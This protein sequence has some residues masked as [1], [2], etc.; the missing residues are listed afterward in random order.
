MKRERVEKENQVKYPQNQSQSL[1]HA[2]VIQMKFERKSQKFS[3]TS[4]KFNSTFSGSLPRWENLCRNSRISNWNARIND[5]WEGK[6]SFFKA[7]QFFKKRRRKTLEFPIARFFHLVATQAKKKEMMCIL[8]NF[9]FHFS[10]NRDTQAGKMAIKSSTGWA[11]RYRHITQE[12]GA[13]QPEEGKKWETKKVFCSISFTSPQLSSHTL[14]R[15]LCRLV[16]GRRKVSALCCV[17]GSSYRERD[18][19]FWW[20]LVLTM[21][22]MKKSSTKTMAWRERRGKRKRNE[23]NGEKWRWMW[24]YFIRFL[25][26][27]FFYTPN[28]IRA[29]GAANSL[30]SLMK[31]QITSLVNGIFSSFS[32]PQA[33]TYPGE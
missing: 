22:I 27:F 31:I 32:Q 29:A 24:K 5:V 14:R 23:N 11:G 16:Y 19:G 10:L 21:I 33:P 12:I 26:L 6:E 18:M 20:R 3:R 17:F 7:A 9:K 13:L 25:L 8:S 1:L 15:I 28:P 4:R 30:M 2:S